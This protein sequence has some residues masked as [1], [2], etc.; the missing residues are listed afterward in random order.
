MAKVL[1]VDD[2][3][4]T[5]SMLKK[6]VLGIGHEVIEASNGREGLDGII[7]EKPDLVIT[8]L[9]MPEMDGIE[10][11]SYVK[12][13]NIKTP[14]VVVSANVQASVRQQCLG[15]GAT[16]FFNKP[17]NKDEIQKYLEGFLAK[18]VAE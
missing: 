12:D 5:R 6:I 9:L 17:P 13:K 15:L 4:F 7:N 14:V 2:S 8:D 11:L 3:M 10:L 1:L 16:E 18:G